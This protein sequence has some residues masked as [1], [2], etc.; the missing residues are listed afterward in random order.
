MGTNRIESASGTPFLKSQWKRRLRRR[1]YRSQRPSHTMR[2]LGTATTAWKPDS[3]AWDA[4]ATQEELQDTSP[5]LTVSSL[6]AM[7]KPHKNRRNHW[8]YVCS[9]TQSRRHIISYTAQHTTCDRMGTPLGAA[10]YQVGTRTLPILQYHGRFPLAKP[11]NSL[12]S[13]RNGL[14]F[15]QSWERCSL[16]ARDI[17]RD[18]FRDNNITR[19]GQTALWLSLQ[20][21]G[22]NIAVNPSS[23]INLDT[24][25]PPT[26]TLG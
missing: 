19:R 20:A 17:I 14:P 23:S 7:T 13:M 21:R 6:T 9:I 16:A 25:T 24:I 5:C 1:T 8:R 12:I 22:L 11:M 15:K 4:T 26:N 3:W 2:W 18:Y 10:S